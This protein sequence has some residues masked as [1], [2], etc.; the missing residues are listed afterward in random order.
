MGGP[1]RPTF[2]LRGAGNTWYIP[3]NGSDFVNAGGS[4]IEINGGAAITAGNASFTLGQPQV[5]MAYGANGIGNV[6]NAI[7]G[8]TPVAG[9]NRWFDGDISEVIAY[10]TALT[11]S[12]VAAVNQY[13]INK[14]LLGLGG[15][16]GSPIASLSPVTVASGATLDATNASATI[17]SLSGPAGRQ[18]LLPGGSLNLGNDGT[19]TTF[20]GTIS[21]AGGNIVM[22]GTGTFTLTRATRS[23]A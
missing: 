20:S 16:G 14:W 23:V 13:L 2:G 10:P 4:Y 5:L 7:G 3:G 19:S 22:A 18:V 17:G 12:Q 8:Y 15:G 11:A 21:G 6:I 1:G 9:N